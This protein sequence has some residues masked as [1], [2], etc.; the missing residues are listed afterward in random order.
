MVEKPDGV[1]TSHLAG[2][3]GLPGRADVGDEVSS[4]CSAGLDGGAFVIGQA[5]VRHLAHGV[6][7]EDRAVEDDAR[8]EIAPSHNVLKD[9]DAR[10]FAR[11][12]AWSGVWVAD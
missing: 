1:P 2:S 11:E 7:D 10:L 9:S 8:G 12:G 3:L 4:D 6:P 5:G